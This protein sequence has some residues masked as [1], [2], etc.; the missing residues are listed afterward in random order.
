MYADLIG[1]KKSK[2]N[3]KLMKSSI[4]TEILNIYVC[5]WIHII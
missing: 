1:S 5:V 3:D 4:V 2:I